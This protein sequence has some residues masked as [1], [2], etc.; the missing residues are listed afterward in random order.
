LPSR[1]TGCSSPRHED[2]ER[3]G[4]S[5]EVK[6]EAAVAGDMLGVAGA[7]AEEVAELAVAAAGAFRRG[8][9]L[10]AA[11]TSDAALRRCVNRPDR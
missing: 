11:H 9:A 7:G 8:E 10:E 4:G 5:A 2:R 1:E 3:S 6:Q